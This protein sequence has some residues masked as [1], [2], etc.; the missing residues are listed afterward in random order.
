MVARIIE[1]DVNKLPSG[2]HHLNSDVVIL[3]NF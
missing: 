1:K 2:S 3:F